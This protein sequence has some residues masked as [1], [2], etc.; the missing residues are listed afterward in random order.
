[1]STKQKKKKAK[2]EAPPLKLDFGCGRT[3]REG[4]IGVDS[5]KFDGVD[6]VFD[7]SSGTWPWA[8]NSV[9]EF[10]CSHMIEHL[11]APQRIHFMNELWRVLKPGAK[12]QVVTPHFGSVRAY[13]DLTHQWPPV[14]TFWY[15]YLNKEW[16]ASQAP[17]NKDYTCDFDHGYGFSLHPAVEVRNQDYQN[18]AV[19]HLLEGAQDLVVTMTKRP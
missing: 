19:I 4:F 18:Y 6:I 9:D 11:T 3:K 7:L 8:D 14:V 1:M 17:H 16:R 2:E 10:N 5:I 15:C 13:G 12:G